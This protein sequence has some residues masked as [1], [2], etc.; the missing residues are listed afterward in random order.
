MRRR[1][2]CNL[3]QVFGHLKKQLHVNCNPA[4]RGL[5]ALQLKWCR[6]FVCLLLAQVMKTIQ[7]PM[8]RKQNANRLQCHV[9]WNKM[10]SWWQLHC[11]PSQCV[12]KPDNYQRE[13]E[14][15]TATWQQQPNTDWA[16]FTTQHR[17]SRVYHPTQAKQNLPPNTGQEEFTI[18][19]RLSRVYHSTQ[20][21]QRLP[22]NTG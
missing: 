12:K 19:H 3:S 20:S 14:R 1:K 13:A 21:E 4:A 15:G 6:V 11:C 7:L 18:W 2:K 8:Y 9:E 22:P 5:L 16:E 17:L 10:L